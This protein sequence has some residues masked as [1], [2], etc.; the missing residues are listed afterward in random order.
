MAFYAQNIIF[1]RRKIRSNSTK[2]TQT[3]LLSYL[4]KLAGSEFCN[5]DPAYN[6]VK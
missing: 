6:I 3:K 5:S 2:K 1:T 4:Y